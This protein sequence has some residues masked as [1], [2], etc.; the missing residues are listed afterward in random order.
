MWERII[1]VANQPEDCRTISAILEGNQYTIAVQ[2]SLDGLSEGIRKIPCGALILDLDGLPVDNR[3]IR[4]F[5]KQNPKIPIFALSSRTFHPELQEA[6][7]LYI[8]ACL[9]KPVDPD[10]LLYWIKSVVHDRLSTKSS[11]G[12][13]KP[14]K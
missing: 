9:A 10:E 6:L 13:Q 2:D 7:S 1:V 11:D 8:S 3:F 5:R 12:E 4:D 14:N